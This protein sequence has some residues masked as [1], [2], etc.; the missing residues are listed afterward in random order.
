VVA[1]QPVALLQPGSGR[2]WRVSRGRGG[3]GGGASPSGG[4]PSTGGAGTAGG[5]SGS[6]G[7]TSGTAGVP[8]IA[9][10]NIFPADNPWNLDISGYPLNPNSAS[11][12][13][14][15]SPSTAFHPDGGRS[16]KSMEFRFRP[17]LGPRRSH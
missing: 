13:A 9:G 3:A 15:M 16:R 10:C 12:L 1:L 6:G 5:A 14:N 17:A 4:T 7:A 11:Y 2:D 8:T